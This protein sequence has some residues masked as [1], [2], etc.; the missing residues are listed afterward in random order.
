MCFNSVMENSCRVANDDVSRP[1]TMA[2]WKGSLP[3][4]RLSGLPLF[5]VNWGRQLYQTNPELDLGLRD[6]VWE[7]ELLNHFHQCSVVNT[8]NLDFAPEMTALTSL[9]QTLTLYHFVHFCKLCAGFLSATNR[10]CIFFP[11]CFSVI[12]LTRVYF[13]GVCE[14]GMPKT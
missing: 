9:L 11:F 3:C 10:V 2:K 7:L 1:A 6:L 8:G 4:A 12:C 14:G 13:A 5:S